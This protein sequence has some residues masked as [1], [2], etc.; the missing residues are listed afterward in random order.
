[1][2]AA[3]ASQFRQTAGQSFTVSAA[4]TAQK[5]NCPEPQS[6]E[7]LEALLQLSK[8]AQ[9]FPMLDLKEQDRL[10][11]ELE[12]YDCHA[13]VI[14][15]LSWRRAHRNAVR[16]HQIHDGLWILR[17]HYHGLERFDDFLDAACQ[18]IHSQRL[19]FDE[20]RILIAA[21]ILGDDNWIEQSQLYKKA[22]DSVSVIADKVLLL[23][24][25][26][27]IFEKKMFM[28]SEVEPIYRRVLKLDPHNPKALRFFKMWYM[29]AMKWNDVAESL[30]ALVE[31]AR[32]QH[33]RQRAAHELAQ[34]Y[35]YNLNKPSKARE[36]LRNYCR[37]SELD[38]RQTL[39][40][41]LERL[42]L[43]DELIGELKKMELTAEPGDE[44]SRVKQKMGLVYLKAK[45][46]KE[47]IE[48]LR[49]CLIHNPKLTLAYESL[50]NALIDSNQA[51][52]IVSVL[53]QLLPNVQLD[54]SRA[55][56]GS[57]IQK[58]KLSEA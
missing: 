52:Q 26:A 34:L 8:R 45:R 41:A 37:E 25:L 2:S 36:V 20:T 54:T 28:E 43:F 23:E 31:G 1:M 39:V 53:E 27:L 49:A 47:A 46:P 29:Q 7:E 21:G 58:V 30:E 50:I 5:I 13:Q 18:L 19:S 24:R 10:L 22:V 4:L 17:A 3:N 56:I 14:S 42:D 15:L 38:I 44:Q 16:E 51:H 11:V 57:L 33:E 35:L 12:S 40:E 6:V 9:Q 32:N 48:C 55:S